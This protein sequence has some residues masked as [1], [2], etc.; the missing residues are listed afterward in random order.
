MI[1]EPPVQA[2]PTAT[3]ALPVVRLLCALILLPAF[4]A[5]LGFVLL[6]KVVL[7]A[8]GIGTVER[9][10]QL[11]RHL[12]QSLAPVPTIALLGNSITREGVD[13]RLLEETAP[14]GWHAQNFA[15]SACSLSE[16]QRAA[17]QAAGGTP[18]RGGYRLA[19]RGH[20]ARRRYRSRQSLRLRHG[21]IRHGLAAIWTRRSSRHRARPLR[22]RC[23]RA[24]SSK[25]CISAP[26]R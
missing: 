23:D 9:I 15:I 4:G 25:S 3:Q 20:G 24:H 18:D 1:E 16:M 21:G 14:A 2:Q 26:P 19:S 11:G 12:D 5:L 6:V 17:S 8:I 10:V 22:R 13:T 7:P